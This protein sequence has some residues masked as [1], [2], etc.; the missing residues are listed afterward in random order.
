MKTIERHRQPIV[1]LCGMLFPTE[2]VRL[3]EMLWT[4][5]MSRHLLGLSFDHHDAPVVALKNRRIT[6]EDQEELIYRLNNSPFFPE[7]AIALCFV[8]SGI[9]KQDFYE[10]AVHESPSLK[11]DSATASN[12]LKDEEEGACFVKVAPR[13]LAKDQVSVHERLTAIGLSADHLHFV[14]HHQSGESRSPAF[15]AP[16][17]GASPRQRDDQIPEAVPALRSF[18]S[19][20]AHVGALRPAGNRLAPERIRT[21]HHLRPP[22]PAGEAR[23]ESRRHPCGLNGVGA[24]GE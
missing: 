5:E 6:V 19:A 16:Y 3:A 22:S 14:G 11:F 8:N 12:T 17:L 4:A 9:P 2:W 24:F 18:G 13:W 1:D 15:I 10:V 23:S 21:S 7:N 20:R